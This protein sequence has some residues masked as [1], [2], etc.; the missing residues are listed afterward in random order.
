MKLRK[1]KRVCVLLLAFVL[2]IIIG[3]PLGIY[4]AKK[5][6]RLLDQ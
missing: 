4:S 3:I 1:R 6:N 2:A 5:K